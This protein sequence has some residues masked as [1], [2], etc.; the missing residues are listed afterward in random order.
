MIWH[1]LGSISKCMAEVAYRLSFGKC[2]VF[3]SPHPTVWL[4][5]WLS[6]DPGESGVNCTSATLS[7]SPPESCWSFRQ[8]PSH[9]EGKST[10]SMSQMGHCGLPESRRRQ[11]GKPRRHIWTLAWAVFHS[12]HP[13]KWDRILPYSLFVVPFNAMFKA[14]ASCSVTAWSDLPFS[15]GQAC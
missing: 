5:R 6:C 7:Y 12:E 10:P 4:Q 9:Q 15:C 3:G 2:L 8:P 13:F 11:W 1:I 14:Q